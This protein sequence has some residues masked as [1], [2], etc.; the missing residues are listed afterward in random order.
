VLL[1]TETS[2]PRLSRSIGSG[3]PH[4]TVIPRRFHTLMD[5]DQICARIGEQQH[6]LVTYDQALSAG[7]NKFA[8]SR[9]CASGRWERVLPRVYRIEGSPVTWHQRLKGA[10][11]WVGDG[12]AISHCSAAALLELQGFSPGPI[13]VSSIRQLRAAGGI[14]LHVVPDLSPKSTMKLRGFRLTTAAWTLIDLAGM[15]GPEPLELALDDAL[16]R[17]LTTIAHLLT[18]LEARGTQGRKGSAILAGLIEERSDQDGFSESALET[19][20]LREYG[21]P[22]YPFRNASTRFETGACSSPA[23]IS[24]IR[25]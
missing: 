7:L 23:L 2:R 13:E 19:R 4:L 9:R 21:R 14:A 18:L 6:G 1:S 20:L 15:V 11:L 17:R 12:A 24:H 22:G 5:P 3:V 10:E 16:R 25:R 8:I